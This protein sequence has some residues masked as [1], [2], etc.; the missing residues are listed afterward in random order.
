[1]A[2]RQRLELRQSTQLVMTP[3][4]RQAIGLLQ[5]SNLDLAGFLAEEMERNPLLEL[6]DPA[7]PA[8]AATPVPPAADTPGAADLDAPRDS[9]YDEAVADLQTAWRG[10]A[11][12]AGA[13]APAEGA[14]ALAMPPSL[15]SHLLGQIGLVAAPAPAVALARLLVDELEEDGYLRASDEELCARHGVGP[16]LLAEALAILRGCEPAGVG[17]RDLAD[18]LALQLAER[19]RLDDAMRALL[20]R[21]PLL[22]EGGPDRLAA[23]LG[24]DIDRLAGM[25]AEIRRLDPRPG[26]AF[27]P[28]DNRPTVPDI[29][30]RRGPDGGRVVELNPDSLPRLIVNRGYARR[31]AARNPAA[32]GFLAECRASASW[33]E[34]ALDQRARTILAVA[35]EIVRRQDRFFDEGVAALSPMTL[36]EVAEAVGMHESTVSRVTAGKTLACERGLIELRFFFSTALSARDGGAAHSA[37]AIRDMIRRLIAA[38][39]PRR[40][41][42]DDA[43]MDKLR[44]QGVD[45]AR[46]TVAKYREALRIP[47]SVERRRRAAATVG[48]VI[49][50]PGHPT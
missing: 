41:L 21:L 16:G 17:A 26:L 23:A 33:L 25:L 32:R 11:G 46:R 37:T 35:A 1:M 34:R 20:D 19:G 5:M 48:R 7:P 40:P 24:T 13:I 15:R 47:S 18:C 30:L 36:R 31:V 45:I 39:D 42:S 3:Q 43:I 50:R 6:A 4:L 22:A 8:L 27:A 28:G 2:I 29:L 14:E 10:R 12:G 9:L 38:E 44:D 49:D